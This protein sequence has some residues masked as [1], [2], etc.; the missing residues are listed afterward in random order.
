MVTY[1]KQL[2]WLLLGLAFIFAILD[3][4]GV[5]AWLVFPVSSASGKNKT[6]TSAIGNT[7]AVIGNPGNS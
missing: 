4:V 5:T 7:P 6:L 2:L 1:L 3:A